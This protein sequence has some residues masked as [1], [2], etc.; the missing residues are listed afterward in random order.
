[1]S[2]LGAAAMSLSCARARGAM[3][4]A[5]NAASDNVKNCR[6]RRIVDLQVR[7]ISQFEQNQAYCTVN[8]TVV[9]WTSVPEVPVTVMVKVPAGVPLGGVAVSS[10]GKPPAQPAR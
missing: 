6:V 2:I 3:A 4:R 8:V 1:M 10:C 7:A 9:E 5:N